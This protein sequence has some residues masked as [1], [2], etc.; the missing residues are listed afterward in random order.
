MS[1]AVIA[2][3]G[4]GRA[5]S[6]HRNF[7]IVRSDFRL[8][9]NCHL[10]TTTAVTRSSPPIF[11]SRRFALMKFEP[12]NLAKCPVFLLRRS[13]FGGAA[14]LRAA[15]GIFALLSAT[16]G[17][18]TSGK[19]ESL[20]HRIND[21]RQGRSEQ[22]VVD[23]HDFT[24]QE[25]ASLAELDGLAELLV[26]RGVVTD[27][28]LQAL[29][30]MSRLRHLRLR[31]ARITDQGAAKIAELRGLRFLNLPDADLSDAG[32]E[33]LTELPELELLRLGSPRI[34]DAGLAAVARM[35]SLKFLHL[36]DI[37]IT[38]AALVHVEAAAQLTSFYVDGAGVTD[39]GIERLLAKRP[40]LH[41]HIDQQHSDRDPNRHEH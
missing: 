6:R 17:C 34:T 21:V 12:P 36:I 19:T 10:N 22:L 35:P 25:M 8:M 20:E 37:P 27:A 7:P 2:S 16:S 24:D 32:L 28:G 13:I 18:S 26:E 4:L 41:L 23:D 3:S 31:G 33:R 38:D 29:A 14:L 5:P 15:A 1:D 30:G 40:Q 39:E 11:P 9:P